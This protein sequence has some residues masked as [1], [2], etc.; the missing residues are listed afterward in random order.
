MGA[1]QSLATELVGVAFMFLAG[2]NFVAL[3]SVAKNRFDIRRLGDNPE[4]RAYTAVTLAFIFLV[5]AALWIWGAEMQDPAMGNARDYGNP[6]QCL[7]D[8]TFQV[9]RSI[10]ATW[11]LASQET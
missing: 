8:A 7:R 3:I 11:P 4:F 2:V 6:L 9:V 5:T 1:Y 10:S